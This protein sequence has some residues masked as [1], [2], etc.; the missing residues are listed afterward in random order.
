[1][2]IATCRPAE[3]SDR[4]T[5][6][7]G[8]QAADDR[9]GDGGKDD[10]GD[11]APCARAEEPRQQRHERADANARNDE[12]A[13]PPGEPSEPGS[14]P[15]SSRACVSSAVSGSRIRSSA[16]SR[17]RVGIDAARHVDL[18]ELDGLDVRIARAARGVRSSSSRSSNSC[19]RLHRHVLAGGHRQRARDQTGEAGERARPRP[20]G[21]APATP[22]ISETFDTRPSLTPKTAARATPLRDVTM[23]VLD[24]ARA[25]H[26]LH[27]TRERSVTTR[28]SP[29]ASR[30]CPPATT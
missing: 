9:G 3:N 5:G 28:P 11:V 18:G 19:L 30:P 14:M 25:A 13:A 20:S 4:S 8:E 29:V 21:P 23:V 22:R 6:E 26:V 10:R 17:A 7:A 2:A 12:T 16:S 15:S 27:A 24:G 1:M